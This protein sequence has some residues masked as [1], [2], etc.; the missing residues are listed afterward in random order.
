M[1]GT[2]FFELKKYV[3]T[4]LGPDTWNRLLRETDLGVRTYEVMADYPDSEVVKLTAAASRI[5]GVPVLAIL[6]DFGEFL[7]PD[8]L[9]M[10]AGLI[11]PKWKTLDVIEQTENQIH[12]VVRLHNRDAHP[13]ELKCVRHSADEV[14]IHY[15]S[16]RKM[17]SVAKG[18]VRGLA[19]HYDERIE[20]S[21]STCM[22]KGDPSC[23]I[24]IR[25]VSH[26]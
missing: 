7:A 5:T 8:L 10:Y 14:V 18:I 6:E 17:C 1:H 16:S 12:R 4:K 26:G 25:L 15:G 3:E 11:D 13:P 24:L 21:E 23:T 2:I 20:I 9:R 19:R 22:L